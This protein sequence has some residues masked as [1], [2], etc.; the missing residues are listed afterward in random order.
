M[1]YSITHQALS[2]R[3][4]TPEVLTNPEPFLGPNWETVLRWWLYFESLTEDQ[5]DEL[6][7]RYDDIEHDTSYRALARNAAIEV[8]GKVNWG[9]VWYVVPYPMAITNELIANLNDPFFL[10]RLVPEFNHK[11]N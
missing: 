2:D 10:P 4:N 7:R 5:V 9:A 3:L 11:Q 1:T 8:I 6:R